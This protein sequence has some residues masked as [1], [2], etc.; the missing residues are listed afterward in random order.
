MTC[1]RKKG[2]S[3]L[4]ELLKKHQVINKPR[5]ARPIAVMLDDLIRESALVKS[6]CDP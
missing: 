4:P 5:S 3:W 6:S 2:K 1:Q